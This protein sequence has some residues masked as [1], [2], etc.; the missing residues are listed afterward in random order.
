MVVVISVR[1]IIYQQQEEKNARACVVLFGSFPPS[2]DVLHTDTR[3]NLTIIIGI[4][5]KY[6]HKLQL[7]YARAG[8]DYRRCHGGCM[9]R[10]GGGRGCHTRGQ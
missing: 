9:E 5:F 6:L 8:K 3:F 4:F 1:K 7:D 2:F 10:I